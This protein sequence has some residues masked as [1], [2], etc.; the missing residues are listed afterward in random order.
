[1]TTLLT[2]HDISFQY[3]K[4]EKGIHNISLSIDKGEWVT[5]IGKNGSGKSTLGKVIMGLLPLQSGAM[6]FDNKCI[7]LTHEQISNPNIAY[8]FQNPDNQFV[9]ITVEEDIAFGLENRQV[10][11]E[12][13][14]KMIDDVLKAVC[15]SKFAKSNCEELSGGQKQRV[16][17]AS[18]LVLQPK[19]LV[20]DEATTMLDPLSRI[21]LLTL[22]KNLQ[23]QY[24]FA[25][26]SITHHHDE[27]FFSDRVIVMNDGA[28]EWVGKTNQLYQ[29]Q[30]FGN[31]GLELTLRQ[32]CQKALQI[33]DTIPPQHEPNENDI[34]SVAEWLWESYL[35]K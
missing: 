29:Q 5:L 14:Q 2:I 8:V 13:M 28:I 22:L 35:N 30:F 18:A 12:N 27:L 21:E 11:R 7:G 24:N 9:G 16:A 20:L 10:K 33:D 32:R 1:M 6:Y 19:L 23:K 34:E 25:I 26:L 17:I 15:M 31:Y 4:S 3:Y